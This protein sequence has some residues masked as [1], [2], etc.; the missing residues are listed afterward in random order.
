VITNERNDR[1]LRSQLEI[2]LPYLDDP[3]VEDIYLNPDGSVWVKTML[4]PD[5]DIGDLDAGD[6]RNIINLV[7]SFNNTVCNADHP[8]L[9]AI[10]PF[11][12][13]R[14]QAMIPP[15]VTAPSFA[16]R[17]RPQKIFTLAEYQS[18][19]V[20]S[21]RQVEVISAA[22][23]AHKNILLVGGTGSGKTTLL[24]ALLHEL[25]T[26]ADRIVSIEDTPELQCSSK[27]HVALFTSES[28][29]MTSCIRA[30]LR[31]RPTRIV[32]G[33]VRGGEALALLK[34]WNT[35]H[36]GGFS[37]VH[38]NDARA[39]LQRIE[40]LAREATEAPQQ[41]FIASTVNVVVFIAPDPKH[42]VGRR[43]QEVL[44]VTGYKDGE[45]TFKELYL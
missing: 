43:V 16:I 12:T 2:I 18:V 42:P 45:Y 5:F 6:A 38:A 20:M 7:A 4:G 27:N 21:A 31:I 39:G 15:V 28:E 8:I 30:A 37:T 9:E 14:F 32:V 22:I 3:H 25:A 35:G 40:Q 13:A 10:L 41:Q 29:S 1:A 19:G 34:A 11:R 36:P 23:Q 17:L 33:E 24:N 44:A 26:S